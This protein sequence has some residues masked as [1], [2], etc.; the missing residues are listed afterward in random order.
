MKV[1]YLVF[2]DVYCIFPPKSAKF[3]ENPSMEKKLQKKKKKS[4]DAVTIKIAENNGK[5]NKTTFVSRK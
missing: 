3:V 5:N 2:N 4:M 1:Y